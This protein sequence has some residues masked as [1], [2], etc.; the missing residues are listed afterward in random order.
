MLQGRRFQVHSFEQDAQA[1]NGHILRYHTRRN[2]L[3]CSLKQHDN[4]FSPLSDK[5]Q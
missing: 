1:L 4:T 2:T 3:L 5:R